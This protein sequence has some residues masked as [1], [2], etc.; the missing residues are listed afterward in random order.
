M[1]AREAVG[2]TEAIGRVP[3]GDAGA[4]YIFELLP[5]PRV[6]PEVIECGGAPAARERR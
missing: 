2:G 1:P 5:R 4:E 6:T 3:P